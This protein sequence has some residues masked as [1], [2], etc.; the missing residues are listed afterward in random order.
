MSTVHQLSRRQARQIAVRA[1]LLTDQRPN[2]LL[3]TVRELTLLQVDPVNAIAPAQHL[4]AWSRLGPDYDT[5]DLDRHLAERN[6]IELSGFVRPAEDI[7]LYRAQMQAWDAGEL[8][9]HRVVLNDW[10]LA[11]HRCRADIL[12]RLAADGP[13][14]T[15]AIP[16]TTERPWKS[17]GWTND[18]NV[19]RML[20]LM[21]A[22]GDVALSGREGGERLWDL[23]D[24]VYLDVPTLPRDEAVAEQDARR[25]AALGL[26]RAKAPVT[27][28]EPNHA[29]AAGEAAVIEGVEGVWRVHPAYLE[30]AGS[31]RQAPGGRAPGGRA[32]RAHRT[33]GF[34]GRAAL[35]C[36]VDRLV[37]DRKRMTEI[38]G[39]DYVLEMYKPKAQRRWGY[40]AL[41]ILWGEDLVGK[42]DATA[43]RKRGLLRVDAI[44][45]DDAWTA[46]CHEAVLTEIE[47]LATWLDLDVQHVG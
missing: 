28:A 17:S 42:L 37:F 27:P 31:V 6:L 13:T 5:G 29:G 1:Q 18:K 38:F 36:P 43:D 47:D 4:V 46:D 39:F 12:A 25:L 45:Q 26:L 44:H 20:E 8:T 15:S 19:A 10:V 40:Y 3:E 22:R 14:P 21:V 2:D 33:P 30:S 11:N 35:L 7:A 34:E 24:R 23:A 16:D 41:P 9:G 32:V